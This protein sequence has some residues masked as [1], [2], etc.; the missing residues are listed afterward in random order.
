MHLYFLFFPV[1]TLRTP[2]S[3]IIQQISANLVL[4]MCLFFFNFFF[5]LVE[6]EFELRAPHL[7]ARCSTTWAIPLALFAPVILK[8]GSCFPPSWPELRSSH[9]ASC[10][11]WDNAWTTTPSFFPHWDGV[12]CSFFP[13]G[14]PG[15]V[16]RLNFT[17]SVAR[18]T[19]MSH[20][21]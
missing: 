5:F 17:S 21:T 13:L 4:L 8:V 1:L 18:I 9:L 20:C 2:A 19:D 16:T 7:Q 12:L 3:S 11:S 10:H 14:W 6:L 15:I